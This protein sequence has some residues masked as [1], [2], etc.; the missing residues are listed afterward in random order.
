MLLAMKKREIEEKNEELNQQNE[1]IASQRDEIEAQ[2]DRVIQQKEIIEK[3]HS[4]ISQSI[5]Y[6]K[7]IQKS[8]FP[9]GNILETYFSDHFVL[10]KPR[11]VVSGDFYWTAHINNCTIV[12]V[13]DCTGHGVPGAFMSMLGISFLHDIVLKEHNTYPGDILN[14]LREAIIHALKQKD[15]VESQK[16]GMD[17]ALC[18]FNS[19]TKQMQFSGANNPIYIVSNKE[20]QGTKTAET[21]VLTEVKGDKMPIAIYRIM[22]PYH[23]HEIQ[24]RQG[25]RLYMFSDGYA[26]QFGGVKDKPQHAGGGKFKYKPFKEL[27]LRI[28]EKTMADQKMILNET[29]ENWRGEIHQIDDVLVIGLKI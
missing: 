2:R 14:K 9:D 6:A 17:I 23:T 29:F 4:D 3:I 10:L 5:D 22:N 8:I 13:A 24:L 12:A 26:D 20:V 18:S 1:E 21:L 19:E 7:R 15:G 28:S 27:I 16:D 25:D 11:D